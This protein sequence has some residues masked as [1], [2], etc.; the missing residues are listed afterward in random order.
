MIEL[1]KVNLAEI[2]H[3]LESCPCFQGQNV[4]NEMKKN[5]AGCVVDVQHNVA[6]SAVML[7]N[8][9][10]DVHNFYASSDPA[11]GSLSAQKRDFNSAANASK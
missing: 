6:K 4:Y 3:L 9:L 1:F 11:L 8:F 2:L 10:A 7:Q 5:V